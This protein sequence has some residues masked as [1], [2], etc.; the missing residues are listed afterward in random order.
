MTS[1]EVRQMLGVTSDW[2]IFIPTDA[3]LIKALMQLTCKSSIHMDIYFGSNEYTPAPTTTVTS[4]DAKD[5]NTV[6]TDPDEHAKHSFLLSTNKLILTQN[7][8]TICREIGI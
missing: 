3:Y 7:D 1:K 5:H 6:T 4:V 8:D 2:H